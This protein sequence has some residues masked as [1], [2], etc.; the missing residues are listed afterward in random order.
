MAQ[1]TL[2]EFHE[3]VAAVSVPMLVADYQKYV[4]KYS[5]WSLQDL[6]NWLQ[7][8]ENI[9]T[10]CFDLGSHASSDAWDLLYGGGE[11]YE[12]EVP[13]TIS[14]MAST[15][16]YPE[17]KKSMIAQLLAPFRGIKSLM[18]EHTVPGPHGRD[19]IVRSYWKAAGGKEHPYSRVV[20]VDL[21]VTD[22]R[23]TEQAAQESAESRSR[24][25]RT[26]GH[27]LRNPLFGVAGLSQSLIENWEDIPEDER[28]QIVQEIQGQSQD[29]M[30]ILED[31]L[32]GAAAEHRS[33]QV[34]VQPL[35][36]ST[37]LTTSDLND[38]E[39][40]IKPTPR[41][42]A[43]PLRTRQI[44]RN[45]AQ[46]ARKYGGPNRSIKCFTDQGN[47]VV[48]V[49]DDG[50]GLSPRLLERLFEPFNAG[51]HPGSTGLGLS[52][53]KALALAMDGDLLLRDDLPATTFEL[54]LPATKTRHGGNSKP[55]SESET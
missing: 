34:V 45:L 39:L 27:E 15:G 40:D 35:D 25:L 37:L 26:V 4:D 46:N 22:I 19:L 52:I 42:K 33:L 13:D 6:E 7:D 10:A 32:A 24:I 20:V 31:L 48:Q 9:R 2:A 5:D 41:A 14:V 28:H 11:D 44:I 53:S 1:F 8:Y 55:K 12:G 21:D 51:D 16:K 36:V 23:R 49:S 38:F 29:T 17:F 18:F 3:L 54:R 43:D 47:V 50:A 30:M